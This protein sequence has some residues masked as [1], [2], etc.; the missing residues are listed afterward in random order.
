MGKAITAIVGAV[1]VTAGAVL[2]AYGFEFGTNLIE[3][4]VAQLLGYA[5]SLLLNPH[6]A[7]LTPIGASYT[8]ALEP[9]AAPPAPRLSNDSDSRGMLNVLSAA[10]GQFAGAH[11]GGRFRLYPRAELSRLGGQHL[12]VLRERDDGRLELFSHTG[13]KP[14]T[15]RI[16]VL[17]TLV[18]LYLPSADASAEP[19]PRVRAL[20][21]NVRE[22][23]AEAMSGE[24]GRRQQV[25]T[26]AVARW[27]K[28]AG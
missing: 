8:G 13:C 11:A 7:P 28:T 21:R 4:G 1:E 24:R 15:D 3:A 18:A 25:M 5:A 26:A 10:R 17:G 6:R 16:T 20:E 27:G 23:V 12:Y 22:L 19:N 9:L 14:L 2:D